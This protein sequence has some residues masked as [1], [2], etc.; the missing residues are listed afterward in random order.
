MELQAVTWL[1]AIAVLGAEMQVVSAYEETENTCVVA[2]IPQ[3]LVPALSAV[4][5]ELKKYFPPPPPMNITGMTDGVEGLARKM[6]EFRLKVVKS[7]STSI[8]ASAETE[9]EILNI[10]QGRSEEVASIIF[11]ET[12]KTKKYLQ[13]LLNLSTVITELYNDVEE[14]EFQNAELINGIVNFLDNE[15]VVPEEDGDDHL[16]V[17]AVIDLLALQ[18]TQQAKLSAV[19]RNME[20]QEKEGAS[21]NVNNMTTEIENSEKIMQDRR[22]KLE[23]EN[24][25]IQDVLQNRGDVS[26]RCDSAASNDSGVRVWCDMDVPSWGGGWT[27][28]LSRNKK[29]NKKNHPTG[30]SGETAVES[31]V[32]Y[33]NLSFHN[34]REGENPDL[35]VRRNDTSI[36][37][38][39]QHD[40]HDQ[41]SGMN[42]RKSYVSSNSNETRGFPMKWENFTRN[43]VTYEAGFG[44]RDGE[45]FLGLNA[46]HVLTSSRRYCLLVV[47]EGKGGRQAW[48]KWGRVR[49]AGRT[50]RSVVP[51][52]R[53][54]QDNPVTTRELYNYYIGNK[55]CSHLTRYV[56]QVGQY[57]AQSSVPDVLASHNGQRFSTFDHDNDASYS[58]NC[59]ELYGGGW[60]YGRCYDV[61]PTGEWEVGDP[62]TRGVVLGRTRREESNSKTAQQQ[63]NALHR[64]KRTAT[65]REERTRMATTTKATEKKNKRKD[66]WEKIMTVRS[67]F[68]Q[69]DREKVTY[70]SSRR[71]QKKRSNMTRLAPVAEL[72][73]LIRPVIA[74]KW[75][76]SQ[77]I[78]G[79]TL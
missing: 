5:N 32:L 79:Q 74:D 52:G 59:A 53:L 51:D 50:L 70:K 60:W 57:S 9:A 20:L 25:S 19:L 1:I 62:S 41:Q 28:L 45:Y 4:A 34:G 56:L 65:L 73:L 37:R 46:A 30:S 49:V 11:N 76:A 6:D 63:A 15:S 44:D 18:Q 2:T 7:I 67:Q 16:P 42:E 68:G 10:T 14:L 12:A 39:K 21:E 54:R 36:P 61:N 55:V 77:D 47:V 8:N 35:V 38:N 13:N 24:E 27:V 33:E 72:K 17:A 43:W 78:P 23:Q 26:T 71:S 22:R 29:M 40:F 3:H 66:D 48:G 58:S 31:D 69:D 75:D 64:T